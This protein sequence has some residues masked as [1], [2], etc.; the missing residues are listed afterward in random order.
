M[1]TLGWL[2]LVLICAGLLILT[3]REI[4]QESRR[5]AMHMAQT[6]KSRGSSA[7]SSSI[8]PPDIRESPDP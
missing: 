7:D 1:I 8:L 5:A 2:V 3:V 6:V 4:R